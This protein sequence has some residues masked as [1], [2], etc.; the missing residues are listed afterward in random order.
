M[1]YKAVDPN[2]TGFSILQL[3]YLDPLPVILS[4][5]QIT[6]VDSIDVLNLRHDVQPGYV[7]L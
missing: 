7:F 4:V 1:P 6:A 2:W 3:E 5:E